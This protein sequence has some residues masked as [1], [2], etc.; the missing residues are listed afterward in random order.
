MSRRVLLTLFTI[1]CVCSGYYEF[2]QIET[3]GY[4]RVKGGYILNDWTIYANAALPLVFAL[5]SV[6]M[7]ARKYK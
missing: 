1:V 6:W 4:L 5:L 2:K 7:I 3:N